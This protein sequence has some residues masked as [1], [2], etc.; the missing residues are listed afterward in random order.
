MTPSLNFLLFFFVRLPC[1]C[2]SRS[3]LVVG[4]IRA[5]PFLPRPSAPFLSF[6]LRGMGRAFVGSPKIPSLPSLLSNFETQAT[7]YALLSFFYI[8]D[9]YG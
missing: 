9:T 6:C 8:L 7:P 4:I 3:S 2:I 5:L 1:A